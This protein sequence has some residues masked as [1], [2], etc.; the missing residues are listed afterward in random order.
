MISNGYQ[1]IFLLDF[2]TYTDT[3][4]AINT[5]YHQIDNKV[6]GDEEQDAKDLHDGW[7]VMKTHL[8]GTDFITKV[9]K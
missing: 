4:Y 1:F 6:F 9:F 7:K 8:F 2:K 3:D 5:F